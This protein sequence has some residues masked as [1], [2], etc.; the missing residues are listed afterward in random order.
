MANAAEVYEV[1]V[2]KN[3]KEGLAHG[4]TSTGRQLGIV[5]AKPHGLFKIQFIDGKPGSLPEKIQGRY[6]G[7]K[8][9]KFDLDKFIEETWKIAAYLS[10][11][12]SKKVEQTEVAA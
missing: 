8:F 9:A 3:V 12:K 6:T 2:C 5:P 1:P 4:V 7:Q 10:P 11:K